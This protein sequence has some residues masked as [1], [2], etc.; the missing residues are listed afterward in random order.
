V[1]LTHSGVPGQEILF[2]LMLLPQST[3][4]AK[5]QRYAVKNSKLI[6]RAAGQNDFSGKPIEQQG[7]YLKPDL[8]FSV[9]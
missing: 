9:L 7:H 3:R 8:L 2:G 6:E 1:S 5:K 4:S